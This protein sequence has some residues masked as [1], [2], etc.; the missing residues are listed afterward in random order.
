MTDQLVPI[1]EEI[2]NLVE[3]LFVPFGKCT[4]ENNGEVFH[5]Q[6]G[7]AE[8]AGNRMHS[9]V[10]DAIDYDQDASVQFLGCQMKKKSDATGKEVV[11]CLRIPRQN[12]S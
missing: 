2:K 4:S 11:C 8:C 1:Y 10:L 3:L 12:T 9:C 5:C 7:P 6:H